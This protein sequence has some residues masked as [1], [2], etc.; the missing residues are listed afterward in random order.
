MAMAPGLKRKGGLFGS[1][2]MVTTPG[3]GDGMT[4]AQE[5]LAP[6]KPKFFGE[7]GVGR[8]IAGNIGDFLLQYSGMDPIYAPAMQQ[9]Q[10]MAYDQQQREM[11][12]RQGLED[13]TWKQN[14]ENA[15]RP[16]PQPTEFERLVAASGLPPEQQTEMIRKYVSNRANP[17]DWIRADNGDGTFQ[18][19]PMGPNGPMTQ[20]AAPQAAP[21]RP[22]GK[23][24]PYNGGQTATPSG[25]FR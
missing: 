19:V 6:V 21:Q 10:A 12:R 14:Y 17:I 25:N 24:T 1:S 4:A 3:I 7:G 13:W 16:A 9:K 5:P 22:K 18:L 11:Q 15:N 20:G 8:S 23:L 2:P